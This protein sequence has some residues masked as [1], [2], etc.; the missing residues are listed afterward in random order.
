MAEY[1]PPDD[2]SETVISLD[3]TKPPEDWS[4]T[5][6][7]LD[8]SSEKKP[9]TSGP[10]V[11]ASSSVEASESTSSSTSR[12]TAVT[13]SVT[14]TGSEATAKTEETEETEEN[15]EG[16]S[17]SPGYY[18][19]QSTGRVSVKQTENVSVR[20]SVLAEDIESIDIICPTRVYTK[21]RAI[22]NSKVSTKTEKNKHA[23]SS[24]TLT[25][26]SIVKGSARMIV[27][28]EKRKNIK[29][30]EKSIKKIL[31]AVL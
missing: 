24:V 19:T 5:T 26:H 27:N 1:D 10:A 23:V 4:E 16:R 25:N 12:S 22:A 28:T 29:W 17:S 9:E 8:K 11:S 2:W 3:Q 30:N 7:I 13:G 21:K 15:G 14:T 31:T 6:V 20:A 18:N